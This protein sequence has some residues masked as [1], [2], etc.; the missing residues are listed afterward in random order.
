MSAAEPGPALVCAVA[1]TADG[2]DL[3]AILRDNAMDA[4]IRLAFEREPD[5]FAG[6]RLM[7]ESHAVIARRGRPPHEAVGMYTHVWLP[8][9]LNGRHASAGYLGGLRVNRAHRHRIRVLRDGYASIPRLFPGAG[10]CRFTSIARD[11]APARRLLEAGLHGLPRYQPVGELVTLALPA[12]RRGRRLPPQLEAARPDDIPALAETFNEAAAAWQFAPRLA[13]DWLEGLDGRNGLAL[14]DFLLLKKEGRIL[15]SLALWDQRAFKQ[16]RV[17]GYRF[18]LGL[19]RPFWN[20]WAAL[21]GR[22]AL[23][24][25]GRCLEEIYLAFAH[26]PQDAATARAVVA[27]ALQRVGA[28]GGRVGLLGLSATHPLLPVLRREFPTQA[29]C[30]VIETVHWPDDPAPC[31]D[32]RPPQPEAALL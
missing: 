2:G 15:A 4:W 31:L 19:A 12:N 24:K 1:T 22:I 27:E 10:A 14:E 29:Y 16:T 32:G 30:T 26:L 13:Q 6:S 25:P 8:V 9:H 11:N 18:P 5:W 3:R 20:L 7:G 17:G 23:P 21:S 28:R